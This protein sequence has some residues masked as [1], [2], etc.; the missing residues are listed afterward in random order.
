M[1]DDFTRMLMKE[2]DDLIEKH[3]A[4]VDCMDDMRG[5]ISCLLASYEATFGNVSDALGRKA[6]AL[7]PDWKE[8]AE[9]FDPT[10]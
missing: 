9:E 1:I 2:R 7:V 3:D 8:R 5:V 10:Q 6:V 4:L